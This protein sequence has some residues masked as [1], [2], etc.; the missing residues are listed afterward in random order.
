MKA[1]LDSLQQAQW[2]L[3]IRPV[4]AFVVSRYRQAWRTGAAFPPIIADKAT[5]EIIS[6]NHR[7][8]SA[9]D[10]FGP[11]FEIPVE[12]RTF[13]SRADAL[14]VMAD[15]NA[16]H[17]EPMD[18][19]TRRRLT[20]AMLVEGITEKE[21]AA[22]L[23]VP[24]TRLERWGEQS[25]TVQIGKKTVARPV[26]TGI[27]TEAV[28]TMTGEEYDEHIERDQG[29]T[30]RHMASQL[31]RWLRNGWVN[32]NDEKTAAAIKELKAAMREAGV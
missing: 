2:V 29:M 11:D 20:C 1:K 7:W 24:V 5:R 9:M 16:K 15:E 26:K 13:K 19:I 27:D 14:R 18:G 12:Y 30:A 28:K 22:I 23:G 3:D 31:T 25:V 8:Q 32:M 17:G 4:D 10:E 6:G 21:V